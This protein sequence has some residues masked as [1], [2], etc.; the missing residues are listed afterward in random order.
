MHIFVINLVEDE[1]RRMAIEAQLKGLGLE[2]E[3]FPAV[4]GKALS[5]AERAASYDEVWYRRNEGRDATPGELGCALSHI[6]IYRLIQERGISHAL[7]LEDDAWLNPNLPQLLAA[8]EAK[9]D[10][11]RKEVIL[12]TWFQSVRMKGFDTLWSCYHSAETRSAVCTHGYVVSNACACALLE[13]LFP[14]RHVADC[15]NWLVQHRVVRVRA[16][17]PTCITAN[18]AHV[19]NISGDLQSPSAGLSIFHQIRRKIWRLFW[20][21]YNRVMGRIHRA[22]R[23]V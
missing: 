21:V 13:E 12:L 20:M 18:M 2:Y 1:A 16:V 3:I 23:R 17:F 7:V 22:I 14:I 8:I 4:R 6:G 5:A 11:K 19:T 15:W 10:P 9:K